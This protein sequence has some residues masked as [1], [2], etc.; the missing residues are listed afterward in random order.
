MSEGDC[1]IRN[2][3]LYC[4]A[5]F[6]KECSAELLERAKRFGQAEVVSAAQGSGY[7][8]SR[9]PD[10]K[11]ARECAR[12]LS[13]SS[14]TF[15][16]QMFAASDEIG[17]LSA[18]DRVAPLVA[19]MMNAGLHGSDIFIE[20]ADTNEAK[21]L[22]PLCR[23]LSGPFKGA[24][25]TAGLLQQNKWKN[26]ADDSRLHVFF[27]ATDRAHVGFSY[28][29]NS[30]PWHMGIPRLKFPSSAPSRS[31]LKLEEAFVVFLSDEDRARRLRRGLTA[32]DLGAS[33][34]GWTWQFVSHGMKVVAVDNGDMDGRLLGS[35]LVQHVHGDGFT[36]VPKKPVD[37][38]VCDIVEQPSRVARLAA[39]WLAKGWC[40][41]SIFNLKLPMKKRYEEVNRCREIVGSELAQSAVRYDL[42]I[43]QLYHDR[44]EVTGFARLL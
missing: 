21:Q 12:S 8:R 27:T 6:E 3:I 33:P 4:R 42:S 40:R 34:G 24:L 44:E 5:G 18:G 17:P 31:T 20:T 2:L 35:G 10:E 13:F 37:W 14:L 19:A 22:S 39:Q 1:M 29:G 28:Q 16:R 32:I 11:S 38:M 23:K 30:S 36:F 43:K 25:E 26:S 41:C 7:C 15:A 9:F